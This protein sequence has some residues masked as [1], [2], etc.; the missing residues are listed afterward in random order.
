M[1][2][3]FLSII[4]IIFSNYSRQVNLSSRIRT[5]IR[6]GAWCPNGLIT[7]KSRQFLEI[8]LRDEF[9]ITATESQGRFA[10]SVGVEFVESYAVEY[11]RTGVGRWVKY[12]DFNGS[13]VSMIFTELIFTLAPLLTNNFTRK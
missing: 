5:E 11:F 2:H 1:H 12:K 7:S 3:N 4:F 9:L 13:I 10:N 8:N 6:G